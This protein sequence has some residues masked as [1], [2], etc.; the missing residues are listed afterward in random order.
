M[1]S[2]EQDMLRDQARRVLEA[3]AAA[4][5]ALACLEHSGDFDRAL[6]HR[7]A[8]LGWTAIT[9]EEEHDGLG[10]G[11]LDLC[12]LAEEIG[13]SAAALPL[14]ASL[15]LAAE[16]LTLWGNEAQRGRFLPAVAAGRCIG[17]LAFAEAGESGVPTAPELRLEGG[18]L[19]GTKEAVLNGAFA[20]LAIV[21]CTDA[22]SRIPGLALV[23]LG[24]A[25]VKRETFPSIDN[26]RGFARLIFQGAEADW[27][28][29][30]G[31]GVARCRALLDRAAIA[32][33]F[34]QIGGAE[35][36]L[37]RARD[38]ALERRAFGQPIGAFQA[39]KHRLA[40][41]YARLELARGAAYEA[42]EAW[43]TSSDALPLTAAAARL[44]ASRAYDF[45][46]TEA[47]H[48]HGALGVT[49]EAGLHLHYRRA[50][51]L[52]L[53]LGS[54]PYW[55]DRLVDHLQ[56]QVTDETSVGEAETMEKGV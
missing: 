34:E 42:V 29:A 35:I 31:D 8:E 54:A 43:I 21:L 23:D 32:T 38:Y 39:I 17:T 48:V 25:A 47:I 19:S 15:C 40:D 6:W 24:Q 28:G 4:D 51:A 33:A 45:A 1:F 14:T 37:E 16:A 53:E 10:L 52:A 55:Q 26:G 46:A 44:A 3:H 5:T 20:D 49:W 36:C 18:R 56:A 11:A 9:I 22:D 13:R 2:P 41:M 7:A 12:V 30:C 50:R 27:L